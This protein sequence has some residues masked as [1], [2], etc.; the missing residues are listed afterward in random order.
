METPKNNWLYPTLLW[1]AIGLV[2]LLIVLSA[3]NVLQLPLPVYFFILLICDLAVTAFLTGWLNTTAEWTGPLLKGN[4]KLTGAAVVFLLILGAGYKFRPVPP[5]DPF[6][7]TI[8]LVDPMGINKGFPGDTLQIA[9]A[10][11]LH[12]EPVNAQGEAVFLGV[13]P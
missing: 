9:F 4:L 1:V 12:S 11:F 8:I 7:L 10:N 3:L 13:N 5:D 2:I 6:V